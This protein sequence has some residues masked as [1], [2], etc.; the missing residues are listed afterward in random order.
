M[1]LSR[2]E[3]ETIINFNEDEATASVYT[4]N[5]ALLHKLEKLAQDQPDKCRLERTSHGGKAADYIVPKAWVRIRPARQLS[6]AELEVR[7][8]ASKKAKVARMTTKHKA[9]QTHDALRMGKDTS[10]DVPTETQLV[11]SGKEA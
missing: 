9:A 7:R 3:Q 6:E 5:V 2:Y 11:Y 10:Q 8:E 4:H 1:Q